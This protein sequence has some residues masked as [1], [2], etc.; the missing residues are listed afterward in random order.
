M[1]DDMDELQGDIDNGK[2]RVALLVRLFFAALLGLGAWEQEMAREI[3]EQY[4]RA[5]IAGRGGLSAMATA[6]WAKL[7]ALLQ[8][9]YEIGRAHV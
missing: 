5:Y 3:Q 7:Q 9:Q 4:T 2:E 6:D 8:D 1:P